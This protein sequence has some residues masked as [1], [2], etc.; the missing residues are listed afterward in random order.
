[1]EEI[2]YYIG[3][4]FGLI[5]IAL[6]FI[7]F[8]MKTQRK[9]ILAQL[10]TAVVFCIH[11]ALIGA[12]TGMA[13]NVVGAIRCVAYYYRNQK[14]SKSPVI[15]IIFTVCMATAGIL[16]W[17]DWYSVFMLLGLVIN[18]VFMASS[19]P[20]RVRASILVSSPLVIVYNVFTTSYGGIVYESVAI[21]SSAIGIVRYIKEKNKEKIGCS[22]Q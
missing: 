10:A 3:Q 6:G 21:I 9:L 2:L 4:G 22:E 16:T 12:L 19:A 5:A 8:Q 17:T 20:Q 11:Y 1:M 15:P 13:M 18:T 7:S 14:G